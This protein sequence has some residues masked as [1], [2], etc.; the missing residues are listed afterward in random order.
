MR[1]MV[2]SLAI[3][4]AAGCSGATV[5]EPEPIPADYTS[6][7]RVDTSGEVPGHGDT[8]RITYVNEAGTEFPGAGEYG[9]GTVIVKEVHDLDG[10]QPGD[11]QYLAV[12]RKLTTAPDGGELQ[13]VTQDDGSGWLFTYLGGGIDSDEENDLTCYDE[14]HRAAPLDHTFRSYGQ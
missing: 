6:W 13:G 11:L 1:A 10:D 9:N 14:C 7:T 12:M 8:Y 2:T 4:L 5:V 3:G